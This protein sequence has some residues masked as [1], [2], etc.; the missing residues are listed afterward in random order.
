MAAFGY[1]ALASDG[2]EMRGVIDADTARAA[3]SSLRER[4]LHRSR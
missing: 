2:S 1:L 4:G 3:R